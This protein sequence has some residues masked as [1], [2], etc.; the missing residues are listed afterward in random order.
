MENLDKNEVDLLDILRISLRYVIS[1][2]KLLLRFG[3]W[4]LRFIYQRKVIIGVFVLIGL[5]YAI[6][7]SRKG[8][9]K[10]K[11]SVE[12]SINMHD[13]Y[14]FNSLIET[15]DRH[16]Q[17]EDKTFIGQCLNLTGEEAKNLLSI[18][19][20]YVIDEMLDGTPDKV[21]YEKVYD[22]KDTTKVRMKDRLVV[23]VVVKE[24]MPLFAKLP[25]ALYYYFNSNPVLK[26]ENEIRIKQIEDNIDAIKNEILMLDSLRK[27]EYFKRPKGG[28]NSSD[29]TIILNEKEKKLYHDD[30]LTLESRIDDLEWTKEI[31]NRCVTFVSEFRL[32]PK[33]VNRITR[34]VIKY[35]GIAFL[36]GILVSIVFFSRKDI[37]GF[38]EN[39]DGRK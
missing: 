6:F 32:Y 23:Q 25:D 29:K 7:E 22:A 4:L 27:I 8:N 34:S 16:C 20:Y 37:K 14:F 12:M 30:L 10:H 24:D 21:D 11:A 13:A 26:A 2:F 3:V 38:L 33:A 15:L 35:V 39:K 36:V 19:S 9:Q 18:K 1:F 28:I 17:N 5:C 31:N